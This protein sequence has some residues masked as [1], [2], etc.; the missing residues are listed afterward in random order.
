MDMESL[1]TGMVSPSAGQSSM[2]TA[3]TASK[4][5]SSSDPVPAAAIQLAESLMS[6]RLV[7]GCA[8]KVGK[9][10][11]DGHAGGGGGVGDGEGG[12][13]ADGHGFAFVS[14]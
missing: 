4:S 14:C 3:W 12:A 1:P 13:L 10:F 6:E 7:D 5:F 8:G 2:P 9:D 11:A